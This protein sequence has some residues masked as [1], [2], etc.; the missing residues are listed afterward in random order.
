MKKRL[1]KA[2][3]LAYPDF[4]LDFTLETDAS[5]Q[6][7]GAVL[8]Q[9]LADQK[10]HPVAFG[11]RALSPHEKNYSVTEL[12]TLAVVRAI[13]HFR[14]Y[15]YGHNVQVITDHSAVKALLSSPSPSG[16][17]ARWWLQ[18][19]GSGLRKV[20]IQYRPGKENVRANALSRNPV[21]GEGG[22][23]GEILDS[24]VATVSTHERGIAELLKTTH[25]QAAPCSF[26]IKRE[27]DQEL[28]QI[29]LCL[30]SGI[31]PCD[32]REVKC[33]AKQVLNFVIIK[34]VLY[35]IE[36]LKGGGSRCRAAVPSHLQRQILEEN[37]GG[38]NAGHFS[39]PRLYAALRRKWW[40]QNMY[41]HAVEFCRSCGECATVVGVGRQKKPP[42][43]PIP[44]QHPFQIVGLDIMELPKTERGNRIE[45]SS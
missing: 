43:H 30:E 23:V 27:K 34:K 31:L 33:V 28:Q 37:H 40:C 19:F 12:E 10:L 45:W 8:S 35:F 15:L 1:V 20:E 9:R 13:K 39:G 18:V 5:H 16:K 4:S 36:S 14:V 11:S 21:W 22:P 25:P 6:G 7:L 38:K 24:Q 2:P 44:V 3:V 26:H 17:H 41:K 29:R 32:E 42:L